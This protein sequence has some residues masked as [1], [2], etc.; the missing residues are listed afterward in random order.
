MTKYG[1]TVMSTGPN[2]VKH[3]NRGQLT[4]NARS[5]TT[6]TSTYLSASLLEGRLTAGPSESS[7]AKI[8]LIARSAVM[9]REAIAK[10]LQASHLDGRQ[11]KN[12]Q[13]KVTKIF[14]NTV[15]KIL[16]TSHLD[17]TQLKNSQWKVWSKVVSIDADMQDDCKEPKA[18]CLAIPS[19]KVWLTKVMARIGGHTRYYAR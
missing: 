18:G 2:M 17:G 1:H 12:S 15:A 11:L 8:R 6:S 10:I 3:E 14:S 19:F 4:T 5:E 13:W 16:Q 7:E 9:R